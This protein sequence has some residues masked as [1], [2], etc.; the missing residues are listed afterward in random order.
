MAV[1][2]TPRLESFVGRTSISSTRSLKFE[3]WGASTLPEDHHVQLRIRAYDLAA[4]KEFELPDGIQSQEFVILKGNQSTELVTFSIPNPSSRQD[5]Q[6]I[7]AAT[8]HDSQGKEIGR[9]VSWPEPFRYLNFP[10]NTKVEVVVAEDGESVALTS[11]YPV[12]GLVAYI[13][14]EDGGDA[15]WMDNMIDLMHGEVVTLRVRGLEGRAVRTRW[16][17]SWEL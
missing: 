16:L 13:A 2:R 9:D 8:I 12:K 14:K 6:L 10:G 17:G 7:V 4:L 3:I 15:D 11:N 1:S 5:F